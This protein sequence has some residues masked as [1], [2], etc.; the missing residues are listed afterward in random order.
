MIAPGRD[1]I[2]TPATLPVPAD[3]EPLRLGE[4]KCCVPG[5]DCPNFRKKDVSNWTTC[6]CGHPKSDHF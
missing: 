2:P 3:H 1:T 5:C 4:G 6:K